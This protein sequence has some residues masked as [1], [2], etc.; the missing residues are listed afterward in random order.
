MSNT[1]QDKKLASIARLTSR[2]AKLRAFAKGKDLS[3][4]SEER[5]GIPLG[6]PILVGHHSERRHRRHLERIDRVVRAGFDASAKADKLE[7]RLNAMGDSRVIQ[8]DNPDAKQLIEAKIAKL[9]KFVDDSKT[10]NKLIRKYKG[11]IPKLDEALKLT[12]GDDTKL[13]ASSM[14]IPDCFGNLGVASFTLT[15]NTAEI[16]RLKGRLNE[17][18][19]L[20][21]GFAGFSVGDV[22]VE[23]VEGQI[24]VEFPDKPS[25]EC[26]DKLKR[27]PLALKWSS[28]SKRWVRKHT[29][30]TQGR[31]FQT[32]LRS[33]L[34]QYYVHN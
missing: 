3:M 4:Y 28:Y 2:I 25:D 30:T 26:R 5:S 14:M 12:F 1:Y 6:Q 15:N 10:L 33:V 7:A 21:E 31:W 19:Q 29:S 20:A 34:E 18:E 32:E 17:L 8:V 11:D 9:Q 13:T 24:Q 16:R 23:L 22:L 27:S